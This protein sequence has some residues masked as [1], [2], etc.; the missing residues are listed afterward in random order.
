[1][2]IDWFTV[3]A[4]ALNFLV[5]IWLLKRFLYKPIL[6]ALDTR[7]KQI[8]AARTD[9]AAR[10]CETE[11]ERDALARERAALES[12]RT[13]LLEKAAQEVAVERERLL[14]QARADAAL[15][16]AQVEA[17]LQSD[18]TRMSG[19]IA[20]RIQREVLAIAGQALRD[21]AAASLEERIEETFIARLRSSSAEARQPLLNELATSGEAGFRS[22]YEIPPARRESIRGA[23]EQT[24]GRSIRLHFDTVPTLLAG[25]ELTAGGY[26]IAWNL[27]GYLAALGQKVESLST[28]FKG[29]R[30]SHR[31]VGSP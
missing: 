20:T 27:D 28:T 4:Q 19:E 18:Q 12:N 10:Q 26:K 11:R 25:V 2:L 17:T 3:G 22:A 1:M 24:L 6:D 30:D 16:R 5:L 15:L 13:S 14:A 8:T 23:L 7:E 29:S 9:M 31:A 21:L